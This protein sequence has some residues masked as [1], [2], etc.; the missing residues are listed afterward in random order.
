MIEALRTDENRSPRPLSAH[1]INRNVRGM[2]WGREINASV[3]AR[4][5]S[6]L[7][8]SVSVERPLRNGHRSNGVT[9][10]SVEVMVPDTTVQP[11]TLTPNSDRSGQR[12]DGAPPTGMRKKW[13]Q[14]KGLLSRGMCRVGLHRGDWGY[15]AEGEC[16]QMRECR[17]CASIHSRTKHKREWV[18]GRANSCF[19]VKNCMRCDFSEGRRTR[20]ASWSD[21]SGSRE[22][23]D[24]CG[25]VRDVSYDD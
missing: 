4:G 11:L 10:A 15:V 13:Q 17:G 25:E 24:R 21:M 14:A 3:Y 16:G 19:Q 20:H 6:T 12:S 1:E 7:M 2:E 18:Y 8:S 9:P 5:N 22:R 23:C